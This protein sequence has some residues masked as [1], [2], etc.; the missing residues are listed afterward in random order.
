MGIATDDYRVWLEPT[1]STVFFEGF[2][3]LDGVEAYQP[4]MDLLLK[5][6]ETHTTCTLNLKALEFLNSSG[7]SMLSMFVVKVRQQDN[8]Q[9]ILQGSDTILWQ[10]KSLRNLQRLMPSLVL[11]FTS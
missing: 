4:I 6:V 3:R 11:T 5:T 7:I 8:A 1:T 10:T 2:L 9:L